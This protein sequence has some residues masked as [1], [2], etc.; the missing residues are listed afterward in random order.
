MNPN[1][2]EDSS[3]REPKRRHEIVAIGPALIVYLGLEM[4]HA[5]AIITLGAS[6]AALALS[7]GRLAHKGVL[8]RTTLL[9]AVGFVAIA[10]VVAITG[11]P[12]LF[13]LKPVLTGL[14]L[15]VALLRNGNRGER[16]Y[17][18][19]ILVRLR[20][21]RRAELLRRYDENPEVR[22]RHHTVTRVWGVGVLAD[23]LVRGAALL[24]LP[25]WMAIL[26]SMPLTVV[27]V[28]AGTGLSLRYLAVPATAEQNRIAQESTE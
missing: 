26:T 13:L 8:T 15:G 5:P 7:V 18:L 3:E 17:S 2:P 23:G 10:A 6:I 19:S 21:R 24:I 28:V 16:P 27:T 9:S 20:P 12:W 11:D 1:P 14:F 4:S 25:P 22:R